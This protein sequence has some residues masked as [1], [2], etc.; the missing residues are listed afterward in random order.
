MCA[1]RYI[2]ALPE[3]NRELDK[4]Q[5]YFAE[6][7]S[8]LKQGSFINCMQTIENFLWRYEQ[9]CDDNLEKTLKIW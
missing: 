6:I 7:Y 3:N 2:S 1:E 9:K 5:R 4:Q 8:H